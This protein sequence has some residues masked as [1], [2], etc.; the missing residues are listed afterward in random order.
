MM[1]KPPTLD[2]YDPGITE[3]CERVLVTLLNGLGPI[4]HSVC[5][6]GG[7][8]PRYL[9]AARPPDVPPHA[10]TTDVDLVIDQALLADIESYATLERNLKRMGFER[11]SNDIG[12]RVSW[13]WKI[14]VNEGM[15]LELELLTESPEAGRRVTPI[16]AH[17][18]VSALNI[19]HSS[20]VTDHHQ[21]QWVTAEL[22][23]GNG[24]AT[25]RVR[26]A[27]LVAFVVLK[28]FAL[29]DRGEPKDAHDII[30]CLQ[31]T[32]GGLDAA[33]PLFKSALEGRHAAAIREALAILQRRFADDEHGQGYGKDGPAKVSAFEGIEDDGTPE[34]RNSLILRRR[35]VSDT[36]TEFLLRIA[37]A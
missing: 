33:A 26:Y 28:A 32:E 1:S 15:F 29:D 23:D 3:A 18:N 27:D 35:E 31:H 36:V 17:G 7:L 30:Y 19:P 37:D 12:Q 9:V 13:R 22:L 14:Q 16:P 11:G 21:E 25:E 2:G 8:T 10:G 24:R 20:I 4:K 5:L 34:A 6:I